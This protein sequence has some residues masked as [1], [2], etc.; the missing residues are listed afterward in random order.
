[1]EKFIRR[2]CCV[3]KN[4]TKDQKASHYLS[5][6]SGRK[7]VVIC[8]VGVIILFSFT[9]YILKRE[10]KYNQVRTLYITMNIVY[11]LLYLTN[12]IQG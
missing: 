4:G 8:T 2:R 11:R 10:N 3:L 7:G 5:N 1:M 6:V 9:F 12:V